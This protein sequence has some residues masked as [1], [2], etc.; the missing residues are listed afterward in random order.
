[1]YISTGAIACPRYGSGP[2]RRVPEDSTPHHHRVHT[3]PRVSMRS[4]VFQLQGLDVIKSILDHIAS[5][6]ATARRLPW[7]ADGL[8][9]HRPPPRP[10]GSTP[11]SRRMHRR[12]LI[13]RLSFVR[14]DGDP[15]SPAGG[16][17]IK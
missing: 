16:I 3:G 12:Q 5:I 9:M 13:R 15:G 11:N 1:M 14:S 2:I 4:Y 10:I 7:R 6:A 8:A 17:R